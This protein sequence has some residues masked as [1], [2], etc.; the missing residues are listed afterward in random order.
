VR[1][2]HAAAIVLLA[3]GVAAAA[4]APAAKLDML[5]FFSG[6]THAENV[7]RIAMKRPARLIVDS[8][9]GKNKAGEFVLI[10]TVREEGK[11]VRERKWVMRPAGPN[12]FT[13]TLSDAVGPV[14]VTVAGARATIRYTM[15]GGLKVDQT[16]D[17]HPDGRT[18][19]NQVTVR[20]FGLKFATVE[21]KVRKLD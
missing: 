21:G 19:L 14:D 1:R 13:G 4:P 16:L 6:K 7:L 10:D 15:K 11:P 9:G 2:G 12:R 17:L 3:A 18:L 8:V 5:G 20:K